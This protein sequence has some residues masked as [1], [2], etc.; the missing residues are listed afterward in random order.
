[1]ATVF[2]TKKQRVAWMLLL[3]FVVNLVSPLTTYALTSGPSQPEL[4]NFQ[5]AGTTD[6]VDVFSGDFSY[7]IPLF[8]LPGP[9]GGYPFNLSYQSGITLDQEASW[10]GLG[11]SLNPGAINRQMRGL[12]DDFRGDAGDFVKTKMSIA[13]NITAGLGVGV[14]LEVFGAGKDVGT[15]GLSAFHN[16]YK[17]LGF[18][19][20]ASAGFAP[21]VRSGMTSG[22]RVGANLSL[23][24]QEGANISPSLSLGGKMGEFGLSAGYNSRSGLSNMSLYHTGKVAFTGNKAKSG[25]AKKM[26]EGVAASASSTLSLAAP[27]YTPQVSMPMRNYSLSA[28]INLGG[29]FWGVFGKGYAKGFYTEQKLKDD[30]KQVTNPAYGYLYYDAGL[31]D[32]KSVLDFNREKDGIVS[33]ETPNLGI[34]S[35]THD[36]YSVTGQGIGAMYRP[37]RNDIGII[38]DAEVISETSGV[39]V[40]ADVGPA[41]SHGGGNLSVNHSKSTSGG[42]TED[43][44]FVKKLGFQSQKLDDAFE[45][46]NFKVHGEMTAEKSAILG[47]IGGINATRVRLEGNNSAPVA[48]TK[49]ENRTW[50]SEDLE[51]A[52]LDRNRKQRN[53]IIQPYTNGQIR[54]GVDDELIQYFENT[55]QDAAGVE[56]VYRRDMYPLHHIGGFTATTGDG[57]RYNY[58]IPVYNKMQE[59]VLFSVAKPGT[60]AS[61]VDVT[62]GETNEPNYNATEKFLKKSELSPFAHSYLLTSIIGPDY[63]DRTDDGVTADDLGYWVKFTYKKTTTP[64]DQYKWREPFSDAHYNEGWITDDLDGKGSYTYGEKDLWYLA[65]A[66]TKSHIAVFNSS[67]ARDDAKGAER[68][69]QT[70]PTMTTSK[71]SSKLVDIKLYSRFAFGT[72]PIKTIEFTTDY[73]LCQQTPNSAATTKGKLTLTKLAFIY[74]NSTRK[75]LNQLTPYEFTYGHNPNFQ[76]D[77]YDRWGNYKSYTAGNSINN[78]DFPY[79]DQNPANKT[80]LDLNAG[81]WSLTQIKTPSG[82]R[83]IVDYEIDDY[84]YVQHKQAMQMTSIVS[85]YDA[86]DKFTLQN[87]GKVRFKLERTF[88]GS[89]TATAQADTVKKYLDMARGQ[90]YFK[91]LM[92]IRAATEAGYDEYISGYADIDFTQPMTLEQVGADWTYGTFRLKLESSYHPFMIRAWQHLRTNQPE[93][94][95]AQPHKPTAATTEG[96]RVSAA[97]AV[98]G[99]FQTLNKMFKQ[100]GSFNG[101]CNNQGYGKQVTASKSWVRLNST[102]KIK[103]GGGLRVRQITMKDNWQHDQE[104]IYGQVYEYTMIENNKTISSGVA[105][106]EPLIGG[107]ENAVRYA[108][109]YTDNVPLRSNNNLYFEYPVNES[110]YPGPQVGYRRVTM[111][112]LASAALAGKTLKN[113]LLTDNNTSVFPS[114]TGVTYGTTGKTVHEYYTARDFPVIADETDKDD[115][116]FN[117]SIPVPFLGN[118]SISKLSSSQGYSIVTNDMH[119][120]LK[121]TSTYRQDRQGKFEVDPISWVK[122]NYASVPKV[123]Q[124]ENVFELRNELVKNLDGTTISFANFTDNPSGE[125][126]SMGQE[127]EFFV[128]MR[129]YED[130]A[131]EGGLSLNMDVVYLPI[132]FAPVP[133]PIPT[134]WPSI[135]KTTSQLRTASSNKIIFRPGILESVEAYDGGS[136]VKTQNERWDMLTGKVVLSRA[137]NNFDNPIYSYNIPAY[138]EYRGISGAYQNTGLKLKVKNVLAGGGTNYYF[139]SGLDNTLLY[140]G[141]EL[142]LF[143]TEAMTTPFTKAIYMGER[144][145]LK[146]L[147]SPTPLT[148]S[149]PTT[150]YGLI[151]R[152]GYRNQLNASIGAIT[153]LE[154]PAKPGVEVNHSKTVTVPSNP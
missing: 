20:D 64:T 75:A 73:T 114:G 40:G 146:S 128:D 88:T 61:R 17:G 43:N 68:Q 30:K 9:N 58:T 54:G 145:G 39:G 87:D 111:M 50:A 131:W 107:D 37:V 34:P 96:G 93:L 38:R 18:S 144:G 1:M 74:G 66:E 12:P 52:S 2:K 140:P 56:Q 11:W 19:I 7:N 151:V 141:D 103:Y 101:Y 32:V 63:V 35:L 25:T 45:P 26:S 98:K 112:S 80:A 104:G 72:Y 124:K 42:W 69:I 13:P 21:S 8:E 76:Q 109:T 153:A 24:S 48:S 89:P 94:A 5:P 3:V 85:P 6:M 100:F 44:N 123:Y 79:V 4:Q 59:E 71:S 120:K 41:L 143:T 62:L 119:G 90:L 129:Q 23:N 65:K 122:Y 110:Y 108:K 22:V 47:K 84:G 78:V 136:L 154:N 31:S 67:T 125:K 95:S 28:R 57:L 105:S 51:S 149:P 97:D 92:N 86:N 49:V 81:A 10:V 118:V 115:A 130:H 70:D 137:N 116:P 133:I 106:Y 15:I 135:G 148:T 53:E 55:Y 46:W 27:G 60:R 36:I 121:Q 147:S 82:S 152:S 132:F 134:I 29:S 127:N 14:S 102:D 99:S 16:T 113:V 138:T 142:M 83:I 126:Y 77:A 33:K 150:Y 91:L 117:L 139:S